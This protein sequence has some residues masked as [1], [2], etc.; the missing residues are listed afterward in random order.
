MREQSYKMI[1]SQPNKYRGGETKVM[2]K[3]LSSLLVLAMIF[4]LLAPAMAFAATG[5]ATVTASTIGWATGA[6][7][8]AG[9]Q[10]TLAV[11]V[12]TSTAGNVRI[13][14]DKTGFIV[15]GIG[16]LN[17]TGAVVN[18]NSVIYPVAAA[19]PY[20]FAPEVKNPVKVGV[21][22]LDQN[23]NG[24]YTDPGDYAPIQ[25]NDVQQSY[26]ALTTQYTVQISP[27]SIGTGTTQNIGVSVLENGTPVTDDSIQYTVTDSQGYSNVNTV[28]GGSYTLAY[29]APDVES[30]VTVQVYDNATTYMGMATVDVSHQLS[31]NPFT[32]KMNDTKT[33]IGKLLMGNGDAIDYTADPQ[34]IFVKIGAN[35]VAHALPAKDGTFAVT[36]TFTEAGDFVIGTRDPG[37]L[38]VG[39]AEFKGTVQ[40]GALTVTA[41]DTSLV[42][43]TFVSNN[44]KF[45]AKVGDQAAPNAVITLSN[46]LIDSSFDPLTDVVAG[47]VDLANSEKDVYLNYKVLTLITDGDGEAIINAKFTKTGT[48]VVDGAYDSNTAGYAD[49]PEY[50]GSATFNVLGAE[51]FNI[52]VSHNNDTIRSNVYE[53]FTINFSDLNGIGIDPTNGLTKV[54]YSVVGPGIDY[55][56]ETTAIGDTQFV[57]GV[58]P[59]QAGSITITVTGTF[60][61][62]STETKMETYDV[63]GYYVAVSLD[64]A[65]TGDVIDF[66]SA[67]TD[68]DGTPINNAKVVLTMASNNT[69]I[70]DF[71]TLDSDTGE[72][73]VTAN[74]LTL[75]GTVTNINNGYYAKTLK[76]NEVGQ[77]DVSVK[78]FDTDTTS[79]TYNTW[80]T[81]ATSSFTV[82]GQNVYQVNVDKSLLA[83]K[84]E[85]LIVQVIDDQGNPVTNL[86]KF[87]VTRPDTDHN[88]LSVNSVTSAATGLTSEITGSPIDTNSDSVVDS[89]KFTNVLTTTPGD[90]I[91]VAST[92]NGE[93]QGEFTLHVVAPQIDFGRAKLTENFKQLVTVTATDPRNG[94]ALDF[95]LTLDGTTNTT[96]HATAYFYDQDNRDGLPALGLSASASKSFTFYILPVIDQSLSDYVNQLSFDITL[97]GNTV[98]NAKVFDVD[99]AKL[100][101]S[102]DV[103]EVYLNANN[104]LELSATDANGQPVVQTGVYYDGHTIGKTDSNGKLVY[105]FAPNASGDLDF[106][107]LDEGKVDITKTDTSSLNETKATVKSVPDNVKPEIHLVSDATTT[108]ASYTLVVGFSDNTYV[109]E[110]YLD[111]TKLPVVNGQIRFNT[112]LKDGENNFYV[113]AVDVAG[114]STDETL[115][116]SKVQP[117]TTKVSF[118]LNKD[119]GLGA[120]FVS[121]GRTFI[122]FR[123]LGNELGAYT[124]YDSAT[125]TVVLKRGDTKVELTLGSKVAVVNGKDVQMDVA[126]IV[127]DGRTYVPFRAVGEMFDAY[128]YYDSAS[129]TVS[130]T[131]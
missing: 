52:Q 44:V 50:V 78:I 107:L 56:S 37:T 1:N 7:M 59:N 36:A 25:V 103:N 81:S 17:A 90:Y 39:N 95:Y 15:T 55:S 122:P 43:N 71:Y 72:Y 38:V 76:V 102:N 9:A 70:T 84:G 46:V 123:A 119:T 125:K 13:N 12:T 80:V 68:Q 40:A 29:S 77:V 85:D 117:Q 82:A 83:G 18:G 51:K 128:V 97:D 74:T 101:V 60:K 88:N 75:D 121:T 48:V 92:D 19:G 110:A 79:P 54:E 115:T 73:T 63:A 35:E 109:K 65:T 47:S 108:D 45:T 129:K 64:K 105:T 21:Y 96:N 86:V 22:P 126:P 58:T 57:K 112:T 5:D 28:N 41:P 61:D 53:T 33:I 31:V 116:V 2:K 62:G 16:D 127:K 69:S 131:F 30:T 10:S 42:A 4:T 67:V 24:F 32:V 91:V 11:S 118:V 23:S 66:S 27:D 113:V 3:R 20:N 114:N 104:T 8:E 49:V 26:A 34:E 6:A 93:K 87:E 89:Y 106:Y 99:Q 130:Y 98:D 111:N 94:S 14:F 100:M 124:Y 120:A